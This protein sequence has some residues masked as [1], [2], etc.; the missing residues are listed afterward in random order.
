[1]ADCRTLAH[2]YMLSGDVN[3]EL[4]KKKLSHGTLKVANLINIHTTVLER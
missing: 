3:T 1:M 2:F 4:S